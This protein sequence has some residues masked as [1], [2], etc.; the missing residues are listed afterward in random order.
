[1]EKDSIKRIAIVGPE[2]TG[3]T[4]LVNRLAQHYSTVGIP[5]YAR[6]YVQELKRPCTLGDIEHIYKTQFE[7]EQQALLK[8]NNFIFV[9][10]ESIIAKVWALDVFKKCPDWITQ[11]ILQHSYSLYLLTSPDIPWEPDA[12]RENPHRSVFF[13]NW[14]E[15]ELNNYQLPYV[16]ID[17][18]GEQ[19]LKNAI[20]AIEDFFLK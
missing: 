11:N 18:V 6:E 19:R 17:G 8:A 13:F 4:T 1:M 9:D 10:T 16:V 12:V 20:N 7:Q 2:S 15:Q 14:Y 5:E 3:K